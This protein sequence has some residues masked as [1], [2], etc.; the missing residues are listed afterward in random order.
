M[1]KGGGGSGE[2]IGE[3]PEGPAVAARNAARTAGS[4]DVGDDA[5]DD[6][7]PKANAQRYRE[8]RKARS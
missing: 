8:A 3:T 2:T 6:E 1:A 5:D 4:A 7:W